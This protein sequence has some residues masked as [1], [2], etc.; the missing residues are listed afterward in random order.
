MRPAVEGEEPGS[1]AADWWNSDA[2]CHTFIYL[3]NW[4]MRTRSTAPPYPPSADMDGKALRKRRGGQ[5]GCSARPAR[6]YAWQSGF[7]DNSHEIEIQI[8]WL[9]TN[10]SIIDRHWPYVW[11]DS[12]AAGGRYTWLM[13]AVIAHVEAI[14]LIGLRQSHCRIPPVVFH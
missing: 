14:V 11:L 13:F 2:L 10:N 12:R 4:I 8:A 7:A 6:F 1:P 5:S 3:F 9:S